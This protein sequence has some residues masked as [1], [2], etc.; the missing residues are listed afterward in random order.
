MP[1]RPPAAC[2]TSPKP[3]RRADVVHVIGKDILIPAHGI[4]WPIMLH[5]CGFPDAQ[6]PRLLVH[7]WWNARGE[8]MSKSLGNVIDP[9]ALADTIGTDALR[10]FLL[11][12]IATGQDS[13]MSDERVL[14][15]NN[16]E[17]ADILGNLLNRT[18]NMA[19]KYLGGQLRHTD[20][21]SAAHTAL[22]AKVAALP[23]AAV[24]AHENLANP[25]S[26]GG[27]HRH[28][29]PGQRIHRSDRPLQA[30]QG[31]RQRGS[32]RQHHGP[33]RRSHGPPQ[34][35]PQSRHAHRRRQN[36]AA[37]RL[38]PARR[39]PTFRSQVG[40][41]ALTATPSASPSP[42]FPKILPPA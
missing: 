26:A 21:D 17:L 24:G 10:Y 14:F 28:R 4:Y 16:K 13:D 18:L 33:H 20:F 23:A 19:E 29:P 34:R 11:A 3:G 27:R 41:P 40:P 42:I 36:A 31:P 2:R 38:D 6:M 12:D 30:G 39:L 35:P 22:R 15:R 25:E 32:G 1:P 7:G 5:A 9:N 37:T 8:K